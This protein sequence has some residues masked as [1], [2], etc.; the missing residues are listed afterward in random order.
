MSEAKSKKMFACKCSLEE[1]QDIV[2]EVSNKFVILTDADEIKQ[3]AQM[4]K[5][6]GHEVRLR[7]IG[8]LAAQELCA[9]D[10]VA[11]L[12]SATSTIVHHLRI[13]TEGGLITS[14]RV[15]KFTIF[16]LNNDLIMHHQIF[17]RTVEPIFVAN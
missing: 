5:G 15:G 2:K 10:I 16:R 12:E 14:R 13:L 7:I 17:D 11:A 3:R 6:L 9:C 1:C 4:F 8:L